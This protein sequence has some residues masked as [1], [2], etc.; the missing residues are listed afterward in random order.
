MDLNNIASQQKAYNEA[1]EAKF[2]LQKGINE[3]LSNELENLQ[4]HISQVESKM[5]QRKAHVDKQP[6]SEP[7]EKDFKIKAW[8]DSGQK[9]YKQ[10]SKGLAFDGN[11][12]LFEA[13]LNTMILEQSIENNAVLNAIGKRSSK[14]LDYRRTVLTQRPQVLLT[15]E[16]TGFAPV[17]ETDASDYSDIVARFTKMYAFPRLT[18]EVLEQ[19]DVDVQANLVKLVAEQFAITM[20]DQILHGDGTG[21][22]TKADPNKLKGICNAAIDKANSYAEALKPA[23]T[24]QRD[25][26]AAV[27]SGDATGVGTSV[28]EVEANL[29]KL[30]LTVPERSQA[31]SKWLMHQDTLSYL[32]QTLKDN[33]GRSL[34]QIEL[35]QEKGVWIRRIMLFGAEIMLNET[36]DAIGAGNAPIVFGDF[37]NGYE[38]VTPTG[39]H[40]IVD[41]ITIPDTYGYYFDRYIGSTV[42]DHEALAVLVC[43]A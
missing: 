21:T 32:M 3:N 4:H 20:Q 11:T 36:M 13:E 16:N 31:S 28:A 9:S 8:L 14:N 19:T 42:A 37:M 33:E 1:L 39:E 35:I 10:Y 29:Y 2:F 12:A 41:N 18:H 7:K 15:A 6:E 38:L 27:A 25:I 24:R 43:Q 23:S 30:M 17:V 34:I 40:S 26:L 22:G 5:Y